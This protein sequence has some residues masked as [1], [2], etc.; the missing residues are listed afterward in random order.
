[1]QSQWLAGFTIA[2]AVLTSLQS[3]TGLFGMHRQRVMMERMLD[4]AL[5]KEAVS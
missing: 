1:L 2:L 3:V 5:A 4:E